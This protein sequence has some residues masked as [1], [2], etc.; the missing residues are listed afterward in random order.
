[1]SKNTW[2]HHCLARC[3]KVP[4]MVVGDLMLDHWVWGS[5]TRIS[6]EAPI[7]V[8]DVQRYTYTAGGAANVVTNLRELG[9]PCFQVGVVGRDDSGRKL[10]AI[11]RREGADVSGLITDPDR[12]TTLKTRIV[13]HSQQ[14]VRADFE[15]REPLADALQDQVLERIQALIERVQLVVFSDYDK[16]LFQPELVQRLFQIAHQAGKKVIGGPKPGNLKRFQGAD[17]VTLNAK[18]ATQASGHPALPLASLLE[19]GAELRRQLPGS[20]VLITRGEHGMSLFEKAGEVHHQPALASQV[21]DVSGAGDTVLSTLSWTLAGGATPA[22]AIEAASHA[23]A[24]VVR[25]VGTA[26]ANPEEILASFS[27]NG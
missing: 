27:A 24:V 3:S 4:V 12:P 25:K 1:M 7:P 18:E 22:Q 20:H 23:A 16:G 10:R 8:V 19:A 11:L 26:T 6:P 14:M 15:S 13:A 21:F 9:V 5:V 17:L 2:L